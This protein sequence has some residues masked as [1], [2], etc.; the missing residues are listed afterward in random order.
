MRRQFSHPGRLV[1][2]TVGLPLVEVIGQPRRRWQAIDVRAQV[3]NS[4]NLSQPEYRLLE[5]VT[6][7]PEA[8][9][10][11]SLNEAEAGSRRTIDAMV[12]QLE[13]SSEGE[14][15]LS[16][17][18]LIGLWKL[19]Y[20]STGTVVTRS[21]FGRLL[22]LLQ[23]LPFVGLLDVRQLLEPQ[24]EGNLHSIPL[25]SENCVSVGSYGISL[26]FCMAMVEAF[27]S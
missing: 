17:P 11:A 19:R 18:D 23:Q 3:G 2:P 15:M 1:A 10:P 12:K 27:N 20:A 22:R 9:S 26:D 4:A 7:L 5:M 16:S 14:N 25:T 21:L 6:T 13:A 8:I 24:S